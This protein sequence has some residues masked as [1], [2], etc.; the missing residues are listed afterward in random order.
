MQPVLA[1][2]GTPR[3]TGLVTAH[4]MTNFH[5]SCFNA[6]Y[7]CGSTLRPTSAFHVLTHVVDA[8]S[9]SIHACF[10][11]A[12]KERR[13]TAA[14]FVAWPELTLSELATI[15]AR[16]HR[17]PVCYSWDLEFNGTLLADGSLGYVNHPKVIG[18]NAYPC[19]NPRQIDSE[20]TIVSGE[21][22]LL[23]LPLNLAG[24]CGY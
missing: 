8:E 6:K 16:P 5:L 23:S 13:R 3:S 1:A 17:T 20:G 2:F 7:T 10:V 4:T 12:S 21:P 19:T 18:S 14:V 22:D 11:S 24:A 9:P 15:A